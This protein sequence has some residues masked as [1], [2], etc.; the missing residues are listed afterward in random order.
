M[1]ERTL[2]DP[3][4]GAEIERIADSTPEA[5]DAAVVLEYT[6]AQHLMLKHAEPAS[7]GFRPA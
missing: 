2:V 1:A 4:T 6:V 5:V 7:Q 3:A